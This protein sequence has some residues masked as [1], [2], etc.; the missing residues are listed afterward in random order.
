[1]GVE[2]LP[3]THKVDQRRF[4]KSIEGIAPRAPVVPLYSCVTGGR[5]LGD[6]DADFW[7]RMCSEPAQFRAMHAALRED[8][9]TDF[10]HVGSVAVER[11]MF[12]S[13][14]PRERPRFKSAE[15]VLAGG[16]S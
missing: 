9:L 4:E 13:F 11:V 8:R 5:V 16:R 14:P 1:M 7:G 15:A 3:H 6:I 12:A 10:I 2:C